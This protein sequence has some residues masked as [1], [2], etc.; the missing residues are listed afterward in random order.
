MNGMRKMCVLAGMVAMAA[1]GRAYYYDATIGVDRALTGPTL[2]V[3]YAGAYAALVE[4]RLNGKSLGTRAVSANRDSGE[5]TFDLDLSL[6]GEGDNQVEIRLYDRSGKIVGSRK[7]TVTAADAARGPVFLSTPQLGAT[8]QG[9]VEIKVGFGKPMRNVYASFFVN[10]QFRSM[11]NTPPYSYVWDTT[12][13]I[14]GWHELEAW[15]VDESSNTFKTRKV[16]VFVNNPGGRTDRAQAT[17]PQAK[18]QTGA[19]EPPV[20]ASGAKP[21]PVRPSQPVG[22]DAKPV[23]PTLKPTEDARPAANPIAGGTVGGEAGAKPLASASSKAVDPGA[24]PKAPSTA[25]VP[26]GNGVAAPLGA[27]AGAKPVAGSA[28]Q[29]AGLRH[30][31]PAVVRPAEAPKPVATATKA[32]A[33]QAVQQVTSV[34]GLLAVTK[35][36]R[37]PNLPTFPILLNN[38]YV[39]FDVNPRVTGGIPL[40][41]FRHLI[42]K[43]GG[44]VRWLGM[45]KAVDAKAD[46]RTIFLRIGD[47][48]ARI[49]DLPVSLEVAP[50]VER[51][52]TIVP[53][54]FL[55]DS[56]DVEVEYDPSTGHVLI[57]TRKK[58]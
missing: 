47:K 21:N 23:A 35:G 57:T 34:A 49:N 13:E 2:T 46:G 37:L 51:G 14:N 10:N 43:A 27:E 17:E 32:G 16:K 45:E 11:V 53:L 9:P 31:T 54:S 12:R 50:F 38:Q 52:R 33:G 48:T 1:A 19:T 28:T 5:I 4:L 55:R 58:D 41:P 30:K 8:V 24:A 44:E 6:I 56:L 39:E 26:V 40:A 18:P 7:T 36:T 25:G 42:E 3:R 29:A 22:T 20:Q 15:V